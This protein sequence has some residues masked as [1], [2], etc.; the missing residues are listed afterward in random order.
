[1]PVVTLTEQQM[2]RCHVEATRR[3]KLARNNTQTFASNNDRYNMDLIGCMGELA[4]SLYMNREWLAE[5]VPGDGKDVEGFEVRTAAH[6]DRLNPKYSLVCRPKDKDAIYVLCIAKGN[7]V[8][9]AGWA[10]RWEVFHLG[11]PMFQEGTYGLDRSQLFKMEDLEE[12]C[13]F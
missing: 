10:G 6:Q 4:V 2:D 11:K 12:I 13:Q 5:G 3:L 1:M 7:Q 9:V 8:V